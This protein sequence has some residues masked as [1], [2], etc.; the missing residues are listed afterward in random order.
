MSSTVTAFKR[1]WPESTQTGFT[2]DTKG[3]TP[4]LFR[5]GEE[6]EQRLV[7]GG[8]WV[9][10]QSRDTDSTG[11][12]NIVEFVDQD[13]NKCQ[14]LMPRSQLAGDKVAI[15]SQLLDRGLFVVA[16][17]KAKGDLFDYLS[18][19]GN[20]RFTTVETTGWHGDGF[21][22]NDRVIGD[23]KYILRNPKPTKPTQ[24]TL[25]SWRDNI[26]SRCVG[27]SR[28]ILGV[29]T[30][31]A[32][33]LLHPSSTE[34]GGIHIVGKSSSGKTKVLTV[35]S[36]VFG[37]E[38]GSWRGTING[39][40]GTAARHSD[41]CLLLDEIGQGE[42][43]EAG[44]AVYI[45][46]NGKG[47]ARAQKDGSDRQIATW[48]LLLLSTGEQSLS[49]QMASAQM[50]SH[51]GQEVRIANV[52]ADAGKGM[53]L[54][55]NIHDAPSPSRFA[56]TLSE[57]ASGHTGHA[58]PAYIDYVLKNKAACLSKVSEVQQAFNEAI[59]IAEQPGQVQRVAKRFALIAAGGEI[60]TDAGI[61][62]WSTGTSIHAA[63]TCFKVWRSS[64][65]PDGSHEEQRAISQVQG[66]L[67][68]HQSRFEVVPS[69]GDVPH[70]KA[71]YINSGEYWIFPHVFTDEICKGLRPDVVSSVLLSK[72]YLCPDTGSR[73]QARR[74]AAGKRQRFYVINSAVLEASAT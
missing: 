51:A 48:R 60:A 16:G 1:Q 52:E 49:E 66:F 31:F 43:R 10:G 24:G 56:D 58:G 38:M 2:I 39:L 53:G 42:A 8:V 72:E 55:E 12:C 44:T 59:E 46:I 17:N 65:A 45:V 26:A 35:A 32:A 21:V 29:S 68:Q 27:N 5:N 57:L 6:G 63:L 47:K 71:G 28:L 23:S 22:M 40:E 73:R 64:W 69:E 11:W 67:Q 4:S 9:T 33:P 30:A 20:Q 54:F 70:N 37:T 15:V 18:Y 41:N 25:D 61:T 36:T 62:G 14:W 13:G 19:G 7:S 50:R 3:K 74:H 34:S